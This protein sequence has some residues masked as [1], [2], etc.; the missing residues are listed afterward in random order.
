MQETG[1]NMRLVLLMVENTKWMA[2]FRMR[3]ELSSSLAATIMAAPN[4]T[5]LDNSL[6]DLCVPHIIMHYSSLI[7]GPMQWGRTISA[8]KRTT[9]KQ[10][11]VSRNWSHIVRTWN[12]FGFV[13]FLLS[14]AITTTILARMVFVCFLGVRR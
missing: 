10:W 4:A 8:L 3:I 12:I 7:I 14:I 9:R 1:V 2:S 6:R 5:G 13:C 11:S